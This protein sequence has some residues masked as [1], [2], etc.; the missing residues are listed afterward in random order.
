MNI[1]GRNRMNTKGL[2]VGFIG[3]GDMGGPIA[4]RIVAA[5][6]P[7]TLWARRAVSLDPYRGS[8]AHFAD[9]P[10]ALGEGSDVVGICVFS[11]ADAQ[12]V[13]DGPDG[14]LA[15]MRPGGVIIVH[16]TISTDD[17]A[18][19]AALAARRGISLLDAPVSG[20]RGRA[21]SGELTI[22]VGGSEQAF[23]IARPI[24]DS[25]GKTVRLMGGL[26]SGQRTKVLNNILGS[27]NL[28]LAA[29]ALETGS[30]LGLNE[31]A[32]QEVLRNSSG[33]SFNLGILV[34]RLLHDSAFARHAASMTR[35]DNA[36]Y[37]AVCTEA[38]IEPN[39]LDQIADE[40]TALLERLGAS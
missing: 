10:K 12:Q 35:K 4:S 30:R 34:D 8:D 26:G 40:A 13:L 5:G 3:L 33:S 15:G 11:G 23:K 19:L 17:T 27:C 18:A 32:I 21:L 2:R 6:F 25:Y 14:V 37:R 28:R 38:G 9:T 39:L 16:S 7:T 22:M 36:L 29:L 31:A 20:A 24:M 1:G